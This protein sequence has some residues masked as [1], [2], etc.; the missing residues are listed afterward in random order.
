VHL[1]LE[2]PERVELFILKCSAGF[3]ARL[4]LCAVS[5]TV[6]PLVAAAN[7]GGRRLYRVVICPQFYVAGIAMT[8]AASSPSSLWNRLSRW[9]RGQL[10]GEVPAEIALCEFDCPHGQ[11]LEDEWATCQRRIA[12]ATGELMPESSKDQK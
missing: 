10:L 3:C 2:K 8:D 12:R 11:C 4:I 5:V 9:F 1:R 7:F 6:G